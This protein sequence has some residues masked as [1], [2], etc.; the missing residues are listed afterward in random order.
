MYNYLRTI[1]ENTLMADYYYID[2]YFDPDEYLFCEV[3][4]DCVTSLLDYGCTLKKIVIPKDEEVFTIS[5][6]EYDTHGLDDLFGLCND[7]THEL[8]HDKTRFI[9]FP[10]RWG[11]ILLQHKFELA[12]SNLA[13]IQDEEEDTNTSIQDVG[14]AFVYSTDKRYGRKIKLTISIWEDFILTHGDN[15]L[16]M[17][18]VQTL[19]SMIE[20]IN[21]CVPSYFAAMNSELKVNID[22]SLEHLKKGELPEG[23]DLVYVGAKLSNLLDKNK[24]TE[25][26]LHYRENTD[27]GTFVQ[28]TDRWNQ[29]SIL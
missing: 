27:I 15:D 11:R 16:H 5:G 6:G 7:H 28:F 20:K 9:S 2:L 17:R 13:D 12:S 29:E 10:P 8:E 18:N 24:L 4:V 25:A 22:K 26:K 21:T 23:N 3:V 14:L 1:M 19:L